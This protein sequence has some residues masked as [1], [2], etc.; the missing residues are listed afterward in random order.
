MSPV[1]VKDQQNCFGAAYGKQLDT[2]YGVT[3]L[4]SKGVYLMRW[5]STAG[6]RKLDLLDYL[7]DMDGQIRVRFCPDH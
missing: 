7:E 5:R 6:P 3:S 4:L 1:T 2:A